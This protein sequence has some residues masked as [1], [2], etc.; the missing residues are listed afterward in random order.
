M[1]A[2]ELEAII[3]R[4]RDICVNE[5]DEVLRQ[6]MEHSIQAYN[7][8]ALKN[9]IRFV[10]DC[11]EAIAAAGLETEQE[12]L[13]RLAHVFFAKEDWGQSFDFEASP[14]LKPEQ[15]GAHGWPPERLDQILDLPQLRRD[16]L[17]PAFSEKFSATLVDGM[18]KFVF[19][20]H[21]EPTVVP[22]ELVAFFSCASGLYDLDYN[23]LGL[24]EKRCTRLSKAS[25]QSPNRS[26][27]RC[28]LCPSN[29]T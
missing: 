15:L 10:R 6:Q 5:D 13:N 7:N 27:K 21:A 22:R 17:K 28:Q 12:K 4:F 18:M 11:V 16:S 29:W 1:D 9:N 23:R 24:C 26:R 25:T 20:E 14:H 3:A 2:E 19:G 8:K